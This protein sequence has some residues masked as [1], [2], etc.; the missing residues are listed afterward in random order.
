MAEEAEAA[1]E[2][3]AEVPAEAPQA[4]MPAPEDGGDVTT[5]IEEQPAP[6]GEADPAEPN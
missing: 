2:G 4:P 3:E 6:A 5:P 1:A